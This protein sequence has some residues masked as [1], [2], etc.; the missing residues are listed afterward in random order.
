MPATL[1][2]TSGLVWGC[3]VETGGLIQNV[4]IKDSSEVKKVKN[5]EG[6]DVGKSIYNRTQEV[7][8]ELYFTGASGLSAIKPGDTFT[9]ASFTPSAGLVICSEANVELDNE[10]YKKITFTAEVCPLITS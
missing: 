8:G 9:L 1:R 2:G 6:E 4:K 5:H 3:T 7:S 10:D